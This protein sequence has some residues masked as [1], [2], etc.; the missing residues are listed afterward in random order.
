MYYLH[1]VTVFELSGLFL[2]AWPRRPPFSLNKYVY[3]HLIDW[4]LV[5]LANVANQKLFHFDK[6]LYLQCAQ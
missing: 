5:S 1:I 3:H 6:Y 2:C 4:L